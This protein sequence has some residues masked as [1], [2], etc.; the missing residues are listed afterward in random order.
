LETGSPQPKRRELLS[1]QLQRLQLLD[2]QIAKLNGMSAQAF[3]AAGESRKWGVKAST[4]PSAAEFSSWVGTCPGK[5]KS[6]E[7][8][9]SSRSAKG[10]N[11]CAACSARW[12]MLR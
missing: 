11:I 1:L 2:E 5:D 8:N 12:L 3:G 7:Q 4:F 10:N 6:A 9:H